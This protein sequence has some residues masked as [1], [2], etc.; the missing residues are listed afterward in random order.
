MR[1]DL[2]RHSKHVL[3]NGTLW[4][5][6]RSLEKLNYY[7]VWKHNASQREKPFEQLWQRRYWN[8][9]FSIKTSTMMD[10]DFHN[11]RVS[12]SA[13]AGFASLHFR[14]LLLV[15][16]RPLRQGSNLKI[17]CSHEQKLHITSYGQSSHG[18]W[19]WPASQKNKNWVNVSYAIG[20]NKIPYISSWSINH[21]HDRSYVSLRQ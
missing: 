2:L 18:F 6:T 14:H 8:S 21:W 11:R 4:P 3:I 10:E 1:V 16:G 9:Y 5:H 13:S 12:A 17:M 20:L 7:N 15:F 19:I